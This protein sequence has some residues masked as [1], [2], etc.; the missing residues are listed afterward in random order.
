MVSCQ[1]K[2]GLPLES[3][4]DLLLLPSRLSLSLP[5]GPCLLTF[6][7]HSPAA[8]HEPNWANS[9]ILPSAILWENPQAKQESRLG[10][11][12]AASVG[13]DSTLLSNG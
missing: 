4:G 8:S 11:R 1:I 5:D 9:M 10:L 2:N 13:L 12:E 7:L 6:L 3:V